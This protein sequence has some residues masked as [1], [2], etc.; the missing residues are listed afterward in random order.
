MT[1]A[2]V[3]RCVEYMLITLY[4]KMKVNEIP[5]LLQCSGKMRNNIVIYQDI[6]V[7]PIISLKI[8]Y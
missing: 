1:A 8:R 4:S 3:Y 2:T 5:L 7:Y 6:S